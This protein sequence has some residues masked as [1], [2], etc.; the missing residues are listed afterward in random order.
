MAN[1]AGTDPATTRFSIVIPARTPRQDDLDRTLNSILE[2]SA[3]IT[4]AVDVRVT[5]VLDADS[6]QST[7][8]VHNSRV[9]YVEES[10]PGL[11]QALVEGFAAAE[12]DIYGYLGVGDTYEP[13]A[14]STL[15]ELGANRAMHKPWWATGMIVTRR[16]NGEV[17]RALLPYRYREAFFSTGL[18]GTMLPTIQ[19]ESTFW[20]AAMHKTLDRERL[21]SMRLAGD[22][23]MWQ[24]FMRST[25]PIIV[26][27]MLGS[28]RWHGDNAS[29]DWESYVA[30]MSEVCRSP[31]PLLRAAASIERLLW[32]LPNSLKKSLN[33]R[34]IRRYRWP[35]G[36]W[37]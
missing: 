20:N 2:Q 36:P 7:K 31:G 27:A 12:G 14:F 29:G 5:V 32:G 17:V 1:R 22:F 23:Y 21:A 18:H 28:F 16:S 25:H 19:A 35:E 37:F 30:E 11:Y 15:V 4:L 3:V 34:G 24:T 26:E 33:R 13:N 8:Q 6:I 9:A 10:K